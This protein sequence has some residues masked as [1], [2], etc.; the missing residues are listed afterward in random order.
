MFMFVGFFSCPD[1]CGVGDVMHVKHKEIILMDIQK[2]SC[3]KMWCFML[4]HQYHIIW[5]QSMKCLRCEHARLGENRLGLWPEIGKN[6]PKNGFWPHCKN[7]GKWPRNRK[8]GPKTHLL[9]TLRP[10]S[11]FLG[12]FPPFF[13]VRP[14]SIS[15]PSSPISDRRPKPIFSQAGM[16]TKPGGFH[17]LGGWQPGTMDSGIDNQNESVLLE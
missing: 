12:H 15:R 4:S 13:M 6:W 7:R 5:G 10:F 11:R 16:F 8:H 1:S 14:K 2:E 3:A 9:A 17:M